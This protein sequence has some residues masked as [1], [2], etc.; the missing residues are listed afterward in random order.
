MPF[1]SVTRLRL[2]SWRYLPGL[3]WYALRS[4]RQA[5]AAPGNL[6]ASTLREAGITFWTC[7]VWR[8]EGSMRAF[9][10][11]GAHRWAM[12]KLVG[13]CDE[14][15]IAHWQQDH[16]A[17]PTWLEAHRRVQQEGRRSKVRHPSAAHERFEIVPPQM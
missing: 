15:A 2:R 5:K 8:D 1:V 6:S 12:P 9:M 3:I 13:W 7:T 11:S 17:P 10:V 16:A 4:Y 14:A